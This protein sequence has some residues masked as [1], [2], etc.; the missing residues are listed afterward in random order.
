MARRGFTAEQIITRLREAEVRLAQWKT[1]VQACKQKGIAE[2]T[3]HRWRK[4]YGGLKIGSGWASQGFR[5]GECTVEEAGSRLV[6]GQPDPEGSFFGNLL[7]PAKRKQAVVR[8]KDPCGPGRISERRACRVLGQGGRSII[9]G[10]ATLEAGKAER[11]Q[12]SA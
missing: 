1:L 4:E 7:S 2:Q 10:G 8:V 9:S 6:A 12:L 5:E 11:S 3:Y